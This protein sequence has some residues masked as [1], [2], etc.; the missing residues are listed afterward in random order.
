[1]EV[2]R[3]TQYVPPLLLSFLA[4]I[5]IYFIFVRPKR[6]EARKYNERVKGLSSSKP[7]KNYNREKGKSI[8]AVS[9]KG[10]RN[11]EE[12]LQDLEAQRNAR[13]KNRTNP[14]L[15]V[16]M[17]QAGLYWS[18]LS[19]V[20]IVLLIG[21]VSALVLI[22]L[23][24][25]KVAAFGFG[26]SFGI[27]IPHLV[28]NFLRSRRLKSFSSEFP[29]ALD[30]IVRGLKSGLPFTDCLKISAKDL[31]YPVSTELQTVVDD[32]ALGVPVAQA[33]E[34]LAERVPIQ[35]VNFLSIVVSIQAKSGGSLA[36]SL[37]NLSKTL[38]E[39]RK[40]AAKI[41]SMSQEAKSSA[42]I[43]GSL[44]FLVCGAIYF[45]SPGYLDL[46]FSRTGGQIVL[47]VSGMWMLFGILVM[48][49]MINFDV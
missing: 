2:L 6:T 34:R 47:F 13:I 10:G 44:P 9:L 38:R 49:S 48:R 5:I 36:E 7:V 31:R 28:V 15:I 1:M 21:L 29:K 3:V 23:G 39:R 11:L 17:R 16:R 25:T 37:D 26:A 42:A 33:I 8:T 30:I 40:L 19:Y 45:I 35:E 14:P 27:I 24:I 41:Q 20:L 22:I 32:Q 12:T 46:L 4:A 43:I 18:K